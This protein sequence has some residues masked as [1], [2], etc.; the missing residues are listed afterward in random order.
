LEKELP[1]SKGAGVFIA[2]WVRAFLP[3]VEMSHVVS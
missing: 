2:R 3:A 1:A